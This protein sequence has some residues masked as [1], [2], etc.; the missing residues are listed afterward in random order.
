MKDSSSKEPLQELNCFKS[1]KVNM[2]KT[3]L[4]PCKWLWHQMVS[5]ALMPVAPSWFR[6]TCSG[7]GTSVHSDPAAASLSKQ[8]GV[9]HARR[10]QG[11]SLRSF[12]KGRKA[13]RICV[14]LKDNPESLVATLIA[15]GSGGTGGRLFGP[16][17]SGC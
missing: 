6:S 11:L 1:Q 8:C 2:I 7:T 3:I 9:S 4:L 12:G 17:V 13:Q 10:R 14:S 15:E 5:G 16:L